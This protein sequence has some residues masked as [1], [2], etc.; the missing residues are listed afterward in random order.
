M[1]MLLLFFNDINKNLF[2]DCDILKYYCHNCTT[3]IK[4]IMFFV[5]ELATKYTY[6]IIKRYYFDLYFSFTKE[7]ST[8]KILNVTQFLE[9]AIFNSDEF[10]EDIITELM[11]F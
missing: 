7:N 6:K 2:F 5:D 10:K 9:Y 11:K 4:E 8:D 1:T 3:E